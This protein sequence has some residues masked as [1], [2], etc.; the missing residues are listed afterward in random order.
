MRVKS[1]TGRLLRARTHSRRWSPRT[2]NSPPAIAP[3]WICRKF[4]YVVTLTRL[5]LREDLSPA[6]QADGRAS[7]DEA[8]QLIDRALHDGSRFAEWTH[9]R[10]DGNDEVPDDSPVDEDRDCRPDC[11]QV[12][13]RDVAQEKLAEA[14]LRDSKARL[15]TLINTLPDLV[16]L[17]DP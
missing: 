7:A 6:T 8:R 4:L 15:R 12:T 10:P 5:I 9:R 16:W 17:K 3:P 1:V 13:I 11:I 14:R 2:G